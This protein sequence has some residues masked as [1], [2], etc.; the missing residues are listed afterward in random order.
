MAAPVLI[1]VLWCQHTSY[2]TLVQSDAVGL[3]NSSFPD[4]FHVYLEMEA[5]WLPGLAT[6]LVAFYC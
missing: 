4:L 3:Q 2:G 6:E 5:N 1:L